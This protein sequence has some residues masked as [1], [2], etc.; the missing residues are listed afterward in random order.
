MAER[1]VIFQASFGGYAYRILQEPTDSDYG[2]VVLADTEFNPVLG[3]EI[4]CILRPAKGGSTL[5][6][7]GKEYRILFATPVPP[8]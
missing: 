2:V 8:P 1:R 3:K 7:G 5:I 6:L 4:S